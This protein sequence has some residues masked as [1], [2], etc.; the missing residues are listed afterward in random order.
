VAARV[1]VVGWFSFLHGEATAGDVL[2]MD[3]VRTALAGA[4]VE[5]EVAWSPVMC[6]PGGVRLEQVAPGRFTHLLFVCGPLH[7]APVRALHGRFADCRRVAVGVSVVDP[8]DPAVTGFHDV[9]P[10]DAPGRAPCV[11]LAAGP[12]PPA[13]PV[14][15]VILTQG[16]REYGARR[17][18]AATTATLSAWLR[19]RDEALLALDTR[20]DPRDWRLCGTPGQLESIVR[21]LDAVVTTRLHGLVLGLKNG[22]PVLAVDPVAGGGKVAAQAAA[23]RWPAVAGADRLDPAALDRHLAWCL[24]PAGRR[25]AAGRRAESR[26]GDDRLVRHALRLLGVVG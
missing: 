19:N 25:A 7:G 15:G 23:W 11:D 6:P 2:S 9:L 26:S 1:L 14:V 4:R 13:L 10:R 8:A 21:R 16:Q 20:L 12:R 3:A 22:V 18:H 5:H 17:R 24:S